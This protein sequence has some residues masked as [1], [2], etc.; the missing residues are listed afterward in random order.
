MTD[1][2]ELQALFRAITK[3]IYPMH[4]SQ[5]RLEKLLGLSQG[6]LSRLRRSDRAMPSRLLV[7]A[8]AQLAVDPVRR[9]QELIEFWT[10]DPL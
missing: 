7:S 10:K 9:I 3:K 5:R 8:L 1:R 4:I 2:Q 6:Y